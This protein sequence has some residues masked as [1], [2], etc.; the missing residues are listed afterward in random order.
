M[1]TKT[2]PLFGFVLF[3]AGCS[4]LGLDKN[5]AVA[6]NEKI[7]GL[8]SKILKVM[9]DLS[10]TFES[11]DGAKMEQKRTQ[12]LKTIQGA[13][14]QAE[15]IKPYKGDSTFRDA[16]IELFKFYEDITKKEYLQIIN[17]LK[18]EEI[19]PEDEQELQKVTEVIAKRE[20]AYDRSFQGAQRAFASKHGL[21]LMD[22]KLQKQIDEMNP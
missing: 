2:L 10:N 14:K 16:G 18:K 1:R 22:N 5:N 13:L 21:I 8:Q 11:R 12:L 4:W 7:I 17:I 15:K 19:T 3:L 9:I 20:E 6:Y